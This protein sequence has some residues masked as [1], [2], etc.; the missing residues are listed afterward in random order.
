MQLL[1]EKM[2]YRG[3]VRTAQKQSKPSSNLFPTKILFSGH[4]EGW[5]LPLPPMKI[6]YVVSDPN[7]F[8]TIKLQNSEAIDDILLVFTAFDN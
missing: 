3:S 5:I 6:H 2:V 1:S 7:S 8:F 4:A